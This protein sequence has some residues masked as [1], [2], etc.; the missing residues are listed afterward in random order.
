MRPGMLPHL[1]VAGALAMIAIPAPAQ[2]V[3]RGAE[4]S[5]AVQPGVSRNLRDLPA[6]SGLQPARLALPVVRNPGPAAPT[7]TPDLSG[8]Y[9]LYDFLY[10]NIPDSPKV[11]VWPDAYYFT[12]NMFNTGSFVFLGANVCAMDRANMP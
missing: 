9:W 12:Y 3:V 5:D 11:G 1:F 4:V 6:A 7:V 8:A 2:P 10:A